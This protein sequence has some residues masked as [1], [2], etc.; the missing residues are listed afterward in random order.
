M[1]LTLHVSSLQ[2]LGHVIKLEGSLDTNTFGQLEAEI[3][4]LVATT[5]F[6][7]VIDL[8]KLTYISSAGI[9]ILQKGSR[10]MQK[11]GGQFKLVNPQ[12]QVARVFAI[13]KVLPSDQLFSSEAELD[14]YLANIQKTPP[15][16]AG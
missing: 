5:P 4:R 8:A 11:A 3:E 13:I 2:Q 7:L 15:P 6:L 10:A 1:P 16:S 12:P 14:A 9:R